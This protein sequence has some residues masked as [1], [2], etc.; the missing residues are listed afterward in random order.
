MLLYYESLAATRLRIP[1]APDRLWR[2]VSNALVVMSSSAWDLAALRDHLRIT[3]S[4][5]DVANEVMRSIG[6]DVAIFRY[7][8][9]TAR[10]ALKGIVDEEHPGGLENF[11]LLF[12][13]SEKSD[14]FNFA[15][16][17]SEA[18]LIGSLLTARS[19]WD[20]FAQLLNLIV[21]TPPIPVARCDISK[22]VARLPASSLSEQITSTLS[23]H[24]YR[25][26]IAF[27]NT[28]KHRRLVQHLFSVSIE[29]NRTGV[30]VGAFTYESE[31]FPVYWGT[32]VLEG[33]IEVKNRLIAAGR[34]LN[35][36]VLP[37]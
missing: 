17:V 12:G 14:E 27:V 25:Y 24:W 13:I 29:D 19:M 8:M 9:A 16:V 37:Q 3:I 34:L 6:Q 7:H 5:F 21:L 15:R 23:S 35:V 22:V 11:K 26:V 31:R 1:I 18:H 30:K 4:E 32:E 20:H 2:L 36:A 10:D 33:A 28:A